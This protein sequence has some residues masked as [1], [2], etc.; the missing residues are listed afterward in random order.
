[1][2]GRRNQLQIAFSIGLSCLLWFPAETTAALVTQ[3]LGLSEGDQ[4]RLVFITSTKIDATAADINVYD[5]HVTSAADSSTVLQALG[6]T[7]RVIGSAAGV[8]ARE[9]TAT[10][11]STAGG[12]LGVP[13]YSLNGGIVAQTYDDFWD[14]DLQQTI[15]HTEQDTTILASTWTGTLWTG[16]SHPDMYLGGTDK[17]RFGASNATN[18]TWISI[19]NGSNHRS[20]GRSLYAISDVITLSHA[21]EPS[22]LYLSGLLTAIF[23]L[24]A[25]R[26]T[27]KEGAT[28]R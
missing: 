12:S 3:P 10:V 5:Q 28:V 23:A 27:D 21:P 7:W 2:R 14:G 26:P 8:N 25:I 19:P 1:M 11:P 16:M 15:N 18:S 13:I 22:S 17:V 4:Y 9:H 24:R 20:L 6:Q